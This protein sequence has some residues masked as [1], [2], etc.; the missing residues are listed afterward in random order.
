MERDDY[1][2]LVEMT[3]NINKII[4]RMSPGD[5]FTIIEHKLN[6]ARDYIWSALSK[7]DK[8]EESKQGV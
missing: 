7:I 2:K 6:C 5:E 4:D 8:I 1:I 3:K